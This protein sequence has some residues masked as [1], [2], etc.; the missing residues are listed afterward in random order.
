MRSV[1]NGAELARLF[2]LHAARLRAGPRAFL[3]RLNA[4]G[5]DPD[6]SRVRSSAAT[7]TEFARG[8]KQGAV[9]STAQKPRQPRT[10]NHRLSVLASYFDYCIRRDTED[11]CGPWEGPINPASG[12]P[13]TEELS[14]GMV[15]RDLPRARDNAKDSVAVFHAR[16]RKPWSPQRF[17]S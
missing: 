13:I 15:G 1:S 14:H 16:C 12:N 11:G 2:C 10:V 3:R 8:A 4:S 5:G 17:R 6:Q 7:V 9:A